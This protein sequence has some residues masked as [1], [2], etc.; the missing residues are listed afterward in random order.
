MKYLYI[1]L[2]SQLI[3]AQLPVTSFYPT[4]DASGLG[5]GSKVD[6]QNNTAI[7][8]SISNPMPGMIAK[9]YVFSTIGT[10][11]SQ[12]DVLHEADVATNDNFGNS[13][14]IEN[15][16]IAVGAI[17]QSVNFSNSGSV[18]LYRMGN[19]TSQFIQ[20][21]SSINN[22]ENDHFGRY[23]K[24][25]NDR[26]YVSASNS[27]HVFDFNG[28]IWNLTQTIS[29]PNT[30]GFGYKIEVD[31]VNLI[32]SSSNNDFWVDNYTIHTYS[33]IGDSNLWAY[34]N[35]MNISAQTVNNN[36]DYKLFNG[37]L[38]VTNNS[39]KKVII[40]ENNAFNWVED[41]SFEYI[42][43]DQVYDKIVVNEDNIFLGSSYYIFQ[44]ERKYPVLHY[45]KVNTIWTEQ[46]PITSNAPTGLDDYFGSS[47]AID[48]EQLLIGCGGET[49]GLRLGKAYLTNTTLGINENSFK[50]F[51][52]YPNPTKDYL[53]VNETFISEIETISIFQIDGKLLE[54]I[55]SNFEII[56]IKN[57]S[58]GTYFVKILFKD[59]NSISRKVIKN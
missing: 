17:N 44:L 28:T 45:K 11:V 38:Y 51:N 9:V 18:Y 22:T 2:F 4:F 42:D 10:S 43:T 55:N 20:K 14:S 36:L 33:N 40:Y 8:S 1:L 3:F 13:I 27:V 58:V 31:N 12:T 49:N 24:L 53:F 50:S 46:T 21:I 56:D 29:V 6:I 54:K 23:V 26:L 25:F 16:N 39:L 34:E 48:G 30:I 59:N 47:M 37:K 19:A 35:S 41:S 15:L 7:V 32:I 52:F 57:L 5:F